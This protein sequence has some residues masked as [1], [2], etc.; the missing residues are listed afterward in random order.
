MNHVIKIASMAVVITLAGCAAHHP[1]GKVS[2]NQYA[3]NGIAA[4]YGGQPLTSKAP[5][6][7]AYSLSGY[8]SPP[9]S[10]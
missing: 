6:L 4:M 7:A 5:S 8:G 9:K 3:K 2:A 1:A 10:K